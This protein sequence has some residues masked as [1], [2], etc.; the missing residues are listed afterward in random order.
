MKKTPSKNLVTV[1]KSPSKK[2]KKQV[3]ESKVKDIKD[4]YPSLT[5]AEA[6]KLASQQ[7]SY[8]PEPRHESIEKSSTMKDKRLLS[9]EAKHDNLNIIDAYVYDEELDKVFYDPNR[10]IKKDG[11]NNFRCAEIGG[12]YVVNG[13]ASKGLSEVSRDI[14]NRI[15]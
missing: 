3:D 12:V 10:F 11:A 14:L 7:V 1:K 5:C 8:E 6:E 15:K 4:R 9:Y 13:K 2:S